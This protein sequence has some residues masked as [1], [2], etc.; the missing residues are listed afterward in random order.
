MRTIVLGAAEEGFAV[1]IHTIGDK[2]THTAWLSEPYSNAA[3]EGECGAPVTDPERM[4]TI[5]LGAAEEGF[6]VRIHTIGDKATHTAWLSEPYS[7]AA[8]EGE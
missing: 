6:A 7:N 8:H 3:H 5:V 2:A 1:R 4:R